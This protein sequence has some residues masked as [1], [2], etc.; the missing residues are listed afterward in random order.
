M[1]R[2]FSI[3]FAL[4]LVLA[5]GLVATVPVA[6]ATLT[7][8]TSLPNVHPNYWTIQAAIDAANPGDT[9][10]VADGTY[11]A[12]SLTSIVITKD[13]LSLVGESRDGT[14]ID[15]GIWGTSGA[16]WPTGIQVYA[17]NVTIKNF[18]VQN[19]T[20]DLISTGGYGILFR[21]FAH[22]TPGEGYIFY[23]GGVVDNVKLQNN[24]SPMYALVHR[25]LTVKNSLI[26][27]NLADGMFI[28]RE[29]DNAV[30]TGNTVIN[31]GNQGIWVGYDWTG[32]GPS[33]NATITNNCV[34]GA[35]EGG[36]SFVH[37]NGAT[38]SGNTITNVA[39]DGWSV[40]AL[41]LKDSC[42]NVQA[43]D[44]TIHN[45]DGSWGGYSGTG[46]GVGIDGTPSSI[47]LHNNNIYSN[48]GYGLRNYSTVGVTAENNWWGAASGPSSSGPGSGDEVSTYVD[49]DPWLTA[50]YTPQTGVAT[51]T[52]TGT[53]YFSPNQ[54]NVAELAAVT[55][56]SGAPVLLPHGMFSFRICCIPAGGTVTLTVTLPT[57]VPVG[58]V[59]WKYQN[60]GWY[61]LPNLS[62]N[63][64]EIMVISLTDGGS[65]DGDTVAGQITDPGG[66]GGAAVGWETY[67]VSKARVLLP[68]ITLLA[69]IMA[70]AVFVGLRRRQTKT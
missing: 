39:G 23:S 52:S 1:K 36:I 15:A 60:G 38:I 70:G 34:D 18:T 49:Y 33:D 4:A 6:A 26:K 10:M 17:Y 3:L 62:D 53:A 24:Y 35:M 59:W 19:F 12:T 14:I 66:P 21:D 28:A 29:C 48:T 55:P 61:S 32:L 64:D 13:N 8:D 44:N 51:S 16:G 5:F 40:G 25:N 31:S 68:W 11:S 30:I 69:A 7:V 57:A 65:G 22:D 41:S 63:G 2:V 42:S 46:N 56:P 58:T 45:N 54:G 50:P 43:Y 47:D 67:P 20:G 9:I 37:S 27:N